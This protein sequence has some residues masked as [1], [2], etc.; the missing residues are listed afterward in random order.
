MSFDA[1][2]RAPFTQADAGGAGHHRRPQA[3]EPQRRSLMRQAC[4]DGVPHQ[5][6]MLKVSRR[7]RRVDA[8]RDGRSV[9]YDD[10]RPGGKSMPLEPGRQEGAGAGS[11][12]GRG[13]SPVRG[14]GR[15]PWPTVTQMTDL[16]SKARAS[17]VYMRVVK[18]TLARKALAGTAFESS[19]RS[20]R[21]RWCW[22]SRRT[23][24]AQRRAWSR[25]SRRTTTSSWRRS[26]ARRAPCSPAKDLDKVASLP[27]TDAGAVACCSACMKA[28]IAEARRHARSAAVKLVR[29]LAAVRD[30]KQAAA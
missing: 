19:V 22:P 2:R 16:R 6:S 5:E 4:A 14:G 10:F 18:N 25:T 12:R 24:R 29:T 28:P 1:G 9:C 3:D 21:D 30:Q 11:Q 13:D 8:L 7:L 17:G 23:I 27:T 20:S 15:I 26:F